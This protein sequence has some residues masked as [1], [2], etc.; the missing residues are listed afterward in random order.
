MKFLKFFAVILACFFAVSCEV[1]EEVVVNENASGT[2]TTNMD[3]SAL[4]DLMQNFGGEE[5]LTKDGMDRVIDTTIMLKDALDTSTKVTPEQKELVKD[6]KINLQMNVKEK[7]FKININI[8]YKDL[9]SLQR[10]MN[11]EGS[12]GGLSDVFKNVFG[13]GGD[14]GM[15]EGAKEPDMGEI[16]SVYNVTVKNGLISRAVNP[17]KFKKIT[18]NPEMA[19]LK[20]MAST[21]MEI[22]YTTTIKLPRA[23]KKSDNPLLKLSDDKKTVTM[24]YNMLE[25]LETPE[26]FAYNLEY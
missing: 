26:K 23:V 14:K 4:I 17:E 5:A 13:K 2:Y 11:G 9:A 7:L 18:E 15:P 21:G 8:P 3:M 6:G 19:Q 22:A 20:Q 10:L 16:G 25:L 1:H 24:K 12:T